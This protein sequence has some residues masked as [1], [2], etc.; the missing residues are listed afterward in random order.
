[1]K[2]SEPQ[3]RSLT[4]TVRKIDEQMNRLERALRHGTEAGL[5]YTIRDSYSPAEKE[6]LLEQIVRVRRVL[7][8]LKEKFHLEPMETDLRRIVVAT[9]SHLWVILEDSKSRRLKGYGEVPEELARE[10]D[11]LLDELIR[12]I[13]ALG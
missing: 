10:L 12:L 3:K 4:V 6:H 7:K 9:A 2:L 5:L 13:D 1:M 11:P 8:I